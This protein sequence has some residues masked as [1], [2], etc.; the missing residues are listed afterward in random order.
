MIRLLHLLEALRH[1]AALSNPA[2]W[3]HTATA[4]ASVQGLLSALIGLAL[5]AGWTIGIDPE[6]L[7]L[8]SSAIVA[9]VSFLLA[10]LNVATSPEIGLA[11]RS[12]E[13]PDEPSESAPHP[14]YAP[15][16]F[17]AHRPLWCRFAN[18]PLVRGRSRHL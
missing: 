2:A 7:M 4:T 12:P 1:G 9:V 3:K 14:P 6:D 18:R 16:P 17:R 11:E 8:L 5:A 13:R 15:R 10:Y